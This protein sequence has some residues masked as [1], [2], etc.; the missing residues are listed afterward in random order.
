MSID[1]NRIKALVQLLGDSDTE[2]SALV[3]EEILRLGDQVIPVLE[4]S[5]LLIENDLQKDRLDAIIDQLKTRKIEDKLQ[6]WIKSEKKDIVDI[7]CDLSEL[8]G[9]E[10]DKGQINKELEQIKVDIWLGLQSN[11]SVVEKVN[12][13]NHVFFHKNGFKGDTDD[14]NNVSN[15]FIDTVLRQRKGN[16]IS[17]SLLYLTIAQRLKLPVFGV[18]LPQHFVLAY[19]DLDLGLLAESD[20]ETLKEGGDVAIPVDKTS[21]PLFYINPFNKGTIFSRSHLMTF[22]KEL[23]I[24]PEESY[25]KIC[26]EEAMVKRILRNLHL[27]Y[28]KLHSE[29]KK[30]QI[31]KLLSLFDR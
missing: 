27:A 23:K 15:S 20:L 3:E 13:F 4:D 29:R 7:W 28:A 22:L 2:V 10:I 14:Y 16:P 19:M 17:L 8:S 5:Y 31:G 26:D 12:Y 9:R 1:N 24:E 18:N 25:Y 21:D 30:D 6:A 11:Q